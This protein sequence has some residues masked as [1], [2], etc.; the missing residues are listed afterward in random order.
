MMYV[1]LFS[2][3]LSFPY[4]FMLR[5]DFIVPCSAITVTREC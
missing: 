4:K 1:I 5:F 3:S 2:G